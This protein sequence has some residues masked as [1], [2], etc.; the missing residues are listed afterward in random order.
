M[1]GEK[2]TINQGVLN[3]PNNPV[4]PFIEGDGR[5]PEYWRASKRVLDAVV[6]KAYNGTKKNRMGK[7][8]LAGE[9]AFNQTGNWLPDESLDA[10]NEFL[11]GIKGSVNHSGRRWN[12]LFKC[13][14]APNFRFICLLAPGSLVCRCAKPG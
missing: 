7:E 5:G 13:G 8:V 4:I 6:E 2:I 14:F 9:K 12:S 10:F 11:V 3:V 1:Q